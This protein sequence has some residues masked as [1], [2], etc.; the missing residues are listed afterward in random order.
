[1]KFGRLLGT[2]FAVCLAE[3]AALGQQQHWVDI[4]P[5]TTLYAKDPD[6]GLMPAPRL[7]VVIYDYVHLDQSVLLRAE[8]VAGHIYGE[9]G[10]ETDWLNCFVARGCDAEGELPQFRVAIHAQ[11]SDVVKDVS[12]TKQLSE[13]WSLG[14]AIPCATTD[15]A[16]LFYIFYSPMRSLAAQQDTSASCIL[17]HVLAHE[18]GHALLGPHA[19]SRSGVMQGK[20]PIANLKRLLSFTTEQSK[21]IRTNLLARSGFAMKCP[22]E[23]T[24]D[25]RLPRLLSAQ[26]P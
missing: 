18:I 16:C 4:R 17:G 1:M 3:S 19:H 22:Q 5:H 23:P 20:L 2:F 11:I 6:P 10:I 7:H 13:H 24:S 12:Q 21:L 25:L 8:K 15:S 9:I 14:F 26:L